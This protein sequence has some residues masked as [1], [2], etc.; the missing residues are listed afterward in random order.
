M[1]SIASHSEFPG[2]RR[3]LLTAGSVL[4]LGQAL[5][6]LARG[7]DS[8]QKEAP[9]QNQSPARDRGP[10]RA[11]SLSK[12]PRLVL[13]GPYAS[14]SN[15]LIRIVDSG[16]LADVADRV[17]FQTWKTPDQLR[18]M[19]IEGKVDFMAMP[20]NVA[21]NLYNRGVA[22]RL[23]NIG[24]WGILWVVCR[25]PAIET[26][27][28][29]KGQEVVLPFR[30]DMPDV[31][32]RLIARQQDL[33]IDRDMKVRYVATPLDAMQL[34]LTR[35]A[36]NALLAE[37]AV[38][39]GLRKSKSFPISAVAPE[40]Y[41]GVSLQREWGRVFGRAPRIPQAGIAV[42]GRQMDNAPLLARF[43]AACVEALQWC[44]NNADACGQAVAERIDA[45]TPEGVA[46]AIRVD[47][48][49]IVSAADA[50]PDLEFLYGKL[51]GYQPGLIGGKLPPADFYGVPTSS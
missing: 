22:L 49:E 30:N 46:D 48:T 35:R 32:F 17:E 21:A 31:L 25:S 11:A 24:V 20:S 34:L 9:G 10:G 44:E 15:P 13:A 16:A 47:Q 3:Q 2:T 43:E 6:G 41:R 37:P 29:L 4:L 18:A 39:V 1:K 23:M 45:L 14:V 50:R 36:D 42:L 27:A 26:M 5:P 28:D 33:D 19:A 38:S 8:A 40:L 7:R 51:L 12:L